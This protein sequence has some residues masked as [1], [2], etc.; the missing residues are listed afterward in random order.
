[1]TPSFFPVV[2]WILLAQSAVLLC[3]GLLAWSFGNFSDALSAWFGGMIAWLPN[4]YFSIRFGIRRDGRTAREVVRSFYL[5]EAVKLLMT[6]GLF[7]LAFQWQGV[8]PLPLF[9]GFLFTLM[10][11][12]FALL[13]R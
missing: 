7:V 11:T 12:W 9:G 3:A 13:A 10:V 2:R 4:V 5:G 6:A 1:M 8:K